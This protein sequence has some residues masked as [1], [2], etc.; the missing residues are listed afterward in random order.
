MVRMVSLALASFALVI[1]PTAASAASLGYNLRMTVPLHCAVY[2]VPTGLGAPAAGGGVSL[3]EFRE[4]CNSPG[5]YQVIV[6]YTPGTLR[7]A[8]ITAGNNQ[9]VLDGSGKALLERSNRPGVRQ[10]TISVI[11]GVDGFNTDRIDLQ[12]LPV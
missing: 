10:R 3:G 5:G 6:N 11:P 1:G 9:V 2:H 12:I 8:R 7:G 4:F